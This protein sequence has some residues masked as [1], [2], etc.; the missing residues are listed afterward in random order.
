[1]KCTVI[2]PSIYLRCQ[3]NRVETLHATSLQF[4]STQSVL[5]VAFSLVVR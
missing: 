2:S 1:M 4:S 3:I 5:K